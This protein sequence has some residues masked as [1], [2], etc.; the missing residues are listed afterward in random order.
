MDRAYEDNET[1]HGVRAGH[2]PVV[3]PS[4]T[5]RIPGT[6]I[7]PFTKSAMR[8][9]S[10]VCSADSKARF[11]KLAAPFPWP[12]LTRTH[13]RGPAGSMNTPLVTAATSSRVIPAPSCHEI[14][15]D[16]RAAFSKSM[17]NTWGTPLAQLSKL[18]RLIILSR[19]C[20]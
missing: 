8:N 6:T 9:E 1:R 2:D 5:A 4:P 16:R 20:F 7:T 11:G 14:G 12:P 10:D 3:P 19:S 18:L 17:S 13:R 15:H